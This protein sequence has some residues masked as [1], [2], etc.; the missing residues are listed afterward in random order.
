MIVGCCWYSFVQIEWLS[1]KDIG[2][3]VRFIS[4]HSIVNKFFSSVS[5]HFQGSHSKSSAKSFCFREF[6]L[7]IFMYAL[8]WV[9]HDIC[10]GLWCFFLWY[11]IVGLFYGVRFKE[12]EKNENN[13]GKHVNCYFMCVVMCV[14]HLSVNW[15]VCVVIY[16]FLFFICT[17]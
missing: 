10:V 11:L 14:V 8:H 9:I 1:A 17:N 3:M 7:S 2:N 5:F 4:F 13:W 6:C 12:C 16:M 15:F